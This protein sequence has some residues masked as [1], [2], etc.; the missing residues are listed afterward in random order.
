[1]LRDRADLFGPDLL[2]DIDGVV[3]DFVDAVD[4]AAASLAPPGTCDWG[5]HQQLQA[6]VHRLCDVPRACSEAMTGCRSA[7]K[8]ILR[9]ALCAQA[10][11]AINQECYAGGNIGHRLAENQARIAGAT[12]RARWNAL[13]CGGRALPRN[14]RRFV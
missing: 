11:R 1:M 4:D 7:S 13:G 8:Y 2:D 10:R 5:R 14:V 12:C 3:D 9:N 6:P